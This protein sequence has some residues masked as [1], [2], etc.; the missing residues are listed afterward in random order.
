MLN[1]D[2]FQTFLSYWLGGWVTGLIENFADLV[3]I[4]AAAD[5]DKTK[6]I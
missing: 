3:K 2:F 6:N 1:Y 4:L 5:F